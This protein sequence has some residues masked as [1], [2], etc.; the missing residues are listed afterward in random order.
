MTE[1]ILY[2]KISKGLMDICE[3]QKIGHVNKFY[4]IINND[5]DISL[6]KLHQQL[7]IDLP[8]NVSQSTAIVVERRNIE[9]LS[10]IIYKVE[11]EKL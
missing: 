1:N 4:L 6:E 8:I 11:G 7:Q 3:R 10:A 2:R 9:I 5:S